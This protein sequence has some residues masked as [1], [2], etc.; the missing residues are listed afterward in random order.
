MSPN[1]EYI[2][3]RAASLSRVSAPR[4]LDFGCGRG[5]V[6]EMGRQRGLEVYGVDRPGNVPS[7]RLKIMEGHRIP[8]DD[9]FFDVVI[10][11]Q[12]FEHVAD[13]PAAL[14]EISRV[15]KP[16]GVFLALFPDSSSWFEG[17]IGL[18]FVHR[19][20]RGLAH[21]YMM[22]CHRVGFGYYRRGK[23]AREWADFMLHQLETDVFYHSPNDLRRWWEDAFGAPP[24]PFERDFMVFRLEQSP[25]LSRFASWGKNLPVSSA[26]SFVCRKRAGIVWLTPKRR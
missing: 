21:A 5:E 1:Y 12:V 26:L 7:D 11:N 16:G 6:I 19:M 10:S 25:L 3:E 13:P 20:S 8:F 15:L 18:Y 23:T 4:I 2:L 17:H 14:A 9:A 22:L 24:S